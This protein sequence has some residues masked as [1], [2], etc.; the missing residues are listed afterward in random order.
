MNDVMYKIVFEGDLLPGYEQAAVQKQLA[1]LFH[2]EVAMA[3]RLFIGKQ[4]EIKKYISFEQAKE[5]VRA[6]SK[7][8]ALAFM[9]P[10]EE[11]DT[12]I[13]ESDISDVFESAGSTK[14][15]AFANYFENKVVKEEDDTYEVPQFI[16]TGALEKSEWDE[17]SGERKVREIEMIARQILQ[18]RNQ[19]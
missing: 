8:G 15:N 18:Q 9:L 5:Y 14:E 3:G 1:E 7:L 19:S 10:H 6:M 17:V 12:V 2:I 16:D 13:P 4:H 11:D